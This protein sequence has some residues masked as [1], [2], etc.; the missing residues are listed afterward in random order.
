MEIPAVFINGLEKEALIQRI[1]V[2]KGGRVDRGWGLA[3]Y[4]ALDSPRPNL[5]QI[6]DMMLDRLAED[7]STG[8]SWAEDWGRVVVCVAP[9]AGL[10]CVLGDMNNNESKKFVPVHTVQKLDAQDMQN[11]LSVLPEGKL[12]TILINN[13]PTTIEAFLISYLHMLDQAIWGIARSDVNSRGRTASYKDAVDLVRSQGFSIR[14]ASE[15]EILLARFLD[16][17]VSVR[18]YGSGV[19]KDVSRVMGAVVPKEEL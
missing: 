7:S 4:V 10:N 3:L 13:Q 18:L 14:L 16:A 19:N 12:G 17:R 6:T 2:D 5:A 1:W 8:F 11:L 9:G 15:E